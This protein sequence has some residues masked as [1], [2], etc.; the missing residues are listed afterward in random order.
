MSCLDEHGTSPKNEPDGIPIPETV[1]VFLRQLFRPWSLIPS[2]SGANK[3]HLKGWLPTDQTRG[4]PLRGVHRT[5]AWRSAR[6]DRKVRDARDQML[7]VRARSSRL[8]LRDWDRLTEIELQS[9]EH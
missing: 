1:R 9:H 6:V 3:R 8:P 5:T 7:Q 2:P 4:A